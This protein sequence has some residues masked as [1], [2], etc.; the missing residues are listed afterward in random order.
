[1]IKFWFALIAL[2]FVTGL[3]PA[4]AQ[5]SN[6]CNLAKDK[7]HGIVLGYYDPRIKQIN[8]A[9]ADII[10]KGG[11]PSSIAIKIGDKFY[12]LPEIQAKLQEDRILAIAYVDHEVSDC[13][14]SLKPYQTIVNSFA[15]IATGGL[16]AALPGKMGYIDASDIM[17][18]YPLGGKD[19]L[20]PK[21]RT[22]I[23][24]ALNIGGDGRRLIE[25]PTRPLR[26][27]FG[28]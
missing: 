28:C 8:D 17:A 21:A 5:T 14:S 13:E 10:A 22:Q 23:L 9:I 26:C 1:M 6:Q 20:V 12:T 24:D 16:L 4:S 11:D 19:A 25:D 2:I 15:N 27:L 3:G 18:G 7:G